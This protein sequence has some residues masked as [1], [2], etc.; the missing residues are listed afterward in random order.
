MLFAGWE[1]VGLSSFLLIA[2]YRHRSQPIRNAIRAYM[3]YRFC[4]LGL[5]LAAWLS[6]LLLHGNNHF[7]ELPQQFVSAPSTPGDAWSHLALSLFVLI[8]ATGKSA[9][10][11]FSYWLPRAMEGPTPSS[12]IFMERCPFI[13][14]SFC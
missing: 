11:P 6:D 10:F 4:D 7:S 13:W 12:A 5:L 1:I 2:F 8:A 14:A 9:Q 3:V